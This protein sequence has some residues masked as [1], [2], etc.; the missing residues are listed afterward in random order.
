MKQT[1]T[2]K[3]VLSMLMALTMLIG[4]MTAVTVSAE[5]VD[6]EVV[7][8]VNFDDY[9]TN[10]DFSKG[11]VKDVYTPCAGAIVEKTEGSEDRVL[12][13][14]GV[15][16]GQHRFNIQNIPY[17]QGET[18]K[19]T[20]SAKANVPAG[21]TVNIG[22]FTSGATVVGNKALSNDWGTFEFEYTHAGDTTNSGTF[23]LNTNV[24]TSPDVNQ[25][26]VDNVVISKKVIKPEVT[27]KIL[28]AANGTVT[29]NANS[30]A[31]GGKFTINK[32]EDVTLT[33]A[34]NSGYH[35]TATVGGVETAVVNN[36]ITL[37][38]VV[39]DTTVEVAFAPTGWELV[40]YFDF[41]GETPLAGLSQVNSDNTKT[42]E[43]VTDSNTNSK[44][45]HV[46]QKTGTAKG[47][48]RIFSATDLV[49][50]KGDV[51]KAVLDAKVDLD[52]TN[53]SYISGGSPLDFRWVSTSVAAGVANYA[54]FGNRQGKATWSTITTAEKTIEENNVLNGTTYSAGSFIVA[55][56]NAMAGEGIWVDNVKLY[57]KIPTQTV[58][59]TA[60]EG[61]SV[62][63]EGNAVAAPITVKKGS[64][65]TL[66]AVPATGYAIS[67]ITVNGVEKQHENGVFSFT[68][69]ADV[70]VAVEF[71]K[72]TSNI[73]VTAG[74]G[75]SVTYEGN[76]VTAPITVNKG[77][78]ATLTIV[79]ESGKYA[80]VKVNGEAVTPNENNQV[81][82]ENVTADAE[83]E[84]I[85]ANEGWENVL[86]ID[87]DGFGAVADLLQATT[88]SWGNTTVAVTDS[89]TNSTVSQTTFAG[90]PSRVFNLPAIDWE[91][92]ATYRLSYD[93]K[94]SREGLTLSPGVTIT[95]YSEGNKSFG[96]RDNGTSNPTLSTAWQSVSQETNIEEFTNNTTSFN[97]QMYINAT[98][99]QAGDII[100]FD[101]I[102]IEK[103]LPVTDVDVT[104]TVGEG[105]SVTCNGEAVTAPIPVAYGE[106]LTLTVAPDEGYF[107]KVMQGDQEL[108]VT[109]GTVTLENVTEATTVTVTFTKKP[110]AQAGIA[111]GVTYEQFTQTD[112]GPTIFIYS[113][114]NNFTLDGNENLNY[115]IKLWNVAYEEDVAELKA[116]DPDTK[117]PA[118]AVANAPFA[119]RAYGAA[120]T[121]DQAYAICPFV[122]ETEG[123]TLSVTF[124]E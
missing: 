67:S 51:F 101:N 60:G 29:Y 75:G 61:G 74:V 120:I 3:K 64:N 90:A 117:Q 53:D 110:D 70:A 49:V 7:K 8:T 28:D 33:V 116:Y 98:N 122:G 94:A 113:K 35:A 30:V 59:V 22:T 77:S 5:V 68:A 24:L 52:P 80:S 6:Y 56:N 57:K 25:T 83:V 13:V 118:I 26:W 40:K 106:T 108:P 55:V 11:S 62:T 63:Y 88:T 14:S 43:I 31:N 16:G 81:V 2:C 46:T 91:S 105:G 32:G 17:E 124:N 76:A 123:E 42:T 20:L 15:T 1:K 72:T 71:E 97:N 58:T 27:V 121:A 39:A 114:L 78:N 47:T 23:V 112:L 36:Q 89:E 86:Y 96:F 4:M 12:S 66:T 9:D 102:R 65:V 85:F 48:L 18:Y 19:I 84:V 99:G 82:L 10:A 79:P 21:K 37:E 69:D 87:F 50:S 41:E 95:G 119:I 104:V 34:P 93:V 38:D 103:K 73:T 109:N 107:A 111:T 44:V 92:G 115:G 54:Y 45:L 100:Y